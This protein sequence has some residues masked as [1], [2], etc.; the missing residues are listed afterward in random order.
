MSR[1]RSAPQDDLLQRQLALAR[2]SNEG[3]AGVG[4]P[5]ID[6]SL[7]DERIPI[8]PAMT[9]TELLAL[10]SRI[11]ALENLVTS[12]L[13][14]A[15]DYQLQLVRDMAAYIAPRPGFTRHPLTIHAAAHM[16]HL[17]ERAALFRNGAT[18]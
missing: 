18:S 6:S 11:V 8:A 9:D 7:L 10:H 13:A 4:G 15:S 5:Q 12:L 17:V 3:G 14:T 1:E 2:W 16:I